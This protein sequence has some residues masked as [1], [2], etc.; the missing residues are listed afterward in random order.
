MLLQ[1]LRALCKPPGGP[2]SI[3]KYVEA[4]V[5]LTGVSG[6]FACGFWTSLHFADVLHM[7]RS[8]LFCL[9]LLFSALAWRCVVWM[10]YIFLLC[11]NGLALQDYVLLAGCCFIGVLK[12]I[13]D[14]AHLWLIEGLVWGTPG[15]A[16]HRLGCSVSNDSKPL[17]W[18]SVRDGTRSEPLQQALPHA[19]PNS[20]NWAGVTTQNSEFWH[21]NFGFN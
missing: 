4:L 8:L 12:C 6:R 1:S 7:Y 2:G 5:R 10:W 16:G 14:M 17:E 13:E 20:C 21:N 19:S 9:I 15:K 3:W 18:F 11:W